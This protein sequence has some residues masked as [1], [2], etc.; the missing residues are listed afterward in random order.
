MG[1]QVGERILS[2]D[3]GRRRWI[4]CTVIDALKAGKLV[5]DS[6]GDA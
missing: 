2:F 5:I 1:V 4:C 6:K 3:I